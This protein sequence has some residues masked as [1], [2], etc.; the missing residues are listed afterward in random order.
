MSA[1]PDVLLAQLHLHQAAAALP[2]W[3]RRR[4]RVG[5]CR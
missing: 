2:A 4:P 3:R 1:A 5:G